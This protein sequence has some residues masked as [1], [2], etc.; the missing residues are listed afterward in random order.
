MYL[1]FIYH[2]Y[3]TMQFNDVEMSLPCPGGALGKLTCQGEKIGNSMTKAVREEKRKC[4]KTT[5]K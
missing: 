3:F 2:Y 5:K 1:N 4:P